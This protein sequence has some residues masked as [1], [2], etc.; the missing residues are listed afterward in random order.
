MISGIYLPLKTIESDLKTIARSLGD[1]AKKYGV[2]V[3]AGQ[4]ATYNGLEIPLLTSTC[5]GEEI[6]APEKPIIGDKVILVGEI[7][8]EAVW[9]NKLA[10][11]DNDEGWRTFTPLPVILSLQRVTNV[12][13]MHDVSEGGVI[14]ALY[15]V[16][17]SYEVG[18]D[19]SSR[20]LVYAEGVNNLK[21]EVLRAPSYGSLIVVIAESNV[22]DVIQKCQKIG[23]PCRIIGTVSPRKGLFINES[24]V[25]EQKRIDID[26]I[27]GSFD[28]I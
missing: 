26:K 27:Y 12:R 13:I 21:G 15:E 18:L 24:K 23:I 16:A 17:E 14:G 25:M 9:L 5:I 10:K 2:I 11:G 3:V 1:E 7:G 28:R 4:T 8:G 6:R 20:N 22:N 19:I